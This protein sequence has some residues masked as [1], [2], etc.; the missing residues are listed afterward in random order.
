VSPDRPLPLVLSGLARGAITGVLTGLAVVAGLFLYA[1]VEGESVDEGLGSAYVFAMWAAF[2]GGAVGAALGCIIGLLL[3][4]FRR[5]LRRI[6][7]WAGLVALIV[8]GPS[9][10]WWWFERNAMPFDFNRDAGAVIGLPLAA[11]ALTVV[12]AWTVPG[13]KQD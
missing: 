10:W 11:V 8:V 7:P 6:G 5:H 3:T 1:I 12:A 2:V 13:G 9:I 4:P